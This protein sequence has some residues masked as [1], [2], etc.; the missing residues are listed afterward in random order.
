MNKAFIATT[1][2]LFLMSTAHSQ[3]VGKITAI[4]KRDFCRVDI[5]TCNLLIK[6]NCTPVHS[7][8]MFSGQQITSS[9]GSL[10]YKRDNNPGYCDTGITANWNCTSVVISRDETFDI[11]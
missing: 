1:F 10:C 11:D 9:T 4:A 5:V 6:D 2:F 8:P 3:S 7:G